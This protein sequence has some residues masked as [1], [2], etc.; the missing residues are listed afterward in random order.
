VEIIAARES[1]VP[2]I[3]SLWIELS[4]YHRDIDPFFTRREG[5]RLEY[6]RRLRELLKSDDHQILIAI[7]DGVV[8]GF[9]LSMISRHP[10]VFQAERYGLICDLAVK[11]DCRHRG[12]GERLLER[13]LGWFDA[14]GIDRIELYVAAKNRIGYSFWEKHG[15]RDY[16]H[17]LYLNRSPNRERKSRK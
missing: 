3:V 17:T 11:S 9:S 4:D 14:G 16:M 6:E 1:D 5:A 10:P 7:E 8:V 2:G 13:I 12:I 15:F